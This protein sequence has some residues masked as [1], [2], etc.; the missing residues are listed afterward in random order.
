[1]AATLPGAPYPEAAETRRRL[2]YSVLAALEAEHYAPSDE[3]HLGYVR[4]DEMNPPGGEGMDGDE[5]ELNSKAK[6]SAGGLSVD[7]RIRRGKNGANP[8]A[9][10]APLPKLIPFE[11]FDRDLAADPLPTPDKSGWRPKRVVLL[12]LD[13]GILAA[14]RKPIRSVKELLCRM[15]MPEGARFFLLGPQTRPC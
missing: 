11:R 4:T 12:W 10:A 9:D 2:R 15:K 8:V 6:L 3:K 5:Y 14:G 7:L 1:M 13:E